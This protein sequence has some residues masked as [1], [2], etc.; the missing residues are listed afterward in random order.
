MTWSIEDWSTSPLLLVPD[1]VAPR[2]ASIV[3]DRANDDVGS[4]TGAVSAGSSSH[5][6][7]TAHGQTAQTTRTTRTTQNES[8]EEGMVAQPTTAP[9]TPSEDVEPQFPEIGWQSQ[10]GTRYTRDN[11]GFSAG[12][13]SRGRTSG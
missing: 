8:A 11:P 13:I 6:A 4:G 2:Q 7:R 12:A 10:L 5:Q 1:C 9:W 3:V